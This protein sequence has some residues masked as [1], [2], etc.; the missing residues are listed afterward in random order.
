MTNGSIVD[1]RQASRSRQELRCAS[2]DVLA[3]T[4]GVVPFGVTLGVTAAVGGTSVPVG[5]VGSL[6]VYGGSA[7]LTTISLLQAGSTAFAAVVAGALVN[8]R[9][10]LYGAALEPRFRGQP[11]WFRLLGPQLIIDQTFLSATRR[12]SFS[13]SSFRA[14]WCWLG[15]LLGSVW[16]SA[17]AVGLVLGPVLPDLPHLW[18][19]GAA[20]FLGILAPRLQGRPSVAAAATAGVTA[21]AVAQVSVG[22]GLVV[23]G[24]AGMAAGTWMEG[25]ADG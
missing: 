17:V 5:L 18:L 2:A 9:L 20:L 16:L 25:R 6:L 11:R 22:L 14:Y 4:P 8:L 13:G 24:L 21:V 1:D 19:V 3:V 10:L 23:G 7:Q 15:G 12:T